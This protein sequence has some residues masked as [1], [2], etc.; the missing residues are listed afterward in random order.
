MRRLPGPVW[1]FAGGKIA[2]HLATTRLGYHRDEFY[3]LS[4]S[5]RLAAS[6]VDF[7]PV[8]PVLVRAEQ[9]L[10]G[11]SLLGL[12]L[13]P[14]LS[15]AVAIVLA[16]LIARELGGDK[17][18]QVLAAFALAVVP[19]FVGMNAALNTVSL[20]TTAWMLV[21]LLF[22]RLVRTGDERLWVGVG[23][24][25]G[26]ALLVKFTMTAY[27][28]GL[29]V[30]VLATPLRRSVSSL[31]LW[32]GGAVGA[33]LV[34]PSIVW[35][36]QNGFPVL[37][38]VGNQGSGGKV[39]GLGG[40]GGYLV[41]LIVLPGIV[42]A[43]L[44]VPGLVSLLRDGIFRAL[45]IA[46]AVA[47]IVFLAASGKG[48]YAA[49]G[50]AVLLC[51]G[52][53]AAIRK[54]DRYPRGL[55]AGIA[56]SLLLALPLAVPLLPVSVLASNADINQATEMGERIGW[57]DLA[58][59]VRRATVSL[60]P[61]ERDRAVVLGSNYALSAAVE[62]YAD[63]YDLPPSVSGHNSAYLWWPEIPRDHVAIAIGLDRSRL[64]RLYASVEE[65]GVVR[66]S[67]GV[68]NYEWGKPIFIGRGPRVSAAE[69]R[70]SI[71]IFTA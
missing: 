23:A 19:A 57:E 24:A 2:F 42:A 15:G 25:A 7:Q 64:E 50:I 63:R 11:E 58:R 31:W 33:A 36:A 61:D 35:Q 47:L 38:F 51:A 10:L 5:K 66:N 40:R 6:Y 60:E 70:E 59:T 54:R 34:A 3:F 32:L 18:A 14:A 48:Y 43:F 20:E 9:A 4:A 44:Y 55:M 17:R 45:G 41:S 39:L 12:R 49:P 21:A 8:T 27:V 52:A 69:L 46:H 30:G 13:L 65:F 37:E 29:G 62:F 22:V 53:V 71:R 67:D 68:E 1:L 56:V 16:A 28:F 26:L